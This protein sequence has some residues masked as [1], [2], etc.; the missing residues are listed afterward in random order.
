MVRL[1][2]HGIINVFPLLCMRT[3]QRRSAA[4]HVIFR[5]RLSEPRMR[6]STLFRCCAWDH[7]RCCAATH[8]IIKV[9]ALVRMRSS[10]SFRC[11]AWD[12]QRLCAATH[13]IIKFVPLPRMRFSGNV[14]PCHAWD[15][16]RRSVPRMR[17]STLF[18]CCAWDHQRRSAATHE[19]IKFVPL[20]RMRAFA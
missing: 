1:E 15:H 3:H 9:V 13:E 6:S 5:Q 10:T 20:P 8:E 12:L 19:I 4:T 17:S 14:F 7:Q 11:H 18:R 16:Q 2:Q